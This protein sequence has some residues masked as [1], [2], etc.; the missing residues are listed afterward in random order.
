MAHSW[1]RLGEGSTNSKL[2]IVAKSFNGNRVLR[3]QSTW[4]PVL[5]LTPTSDI[6]VESK[7]L[8]IQEAIAEKR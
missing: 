4:L 3:L 7:V 6:E 1:S 5:D 2:Q 8:K